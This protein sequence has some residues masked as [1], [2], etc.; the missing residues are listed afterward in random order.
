MSAGPSLPDAKGPGRDGGRRV[1]DRHLVGCETDDCTKSEEGALPSGFI[2]GGGSRT[3]DR[4]EKRCVEDILANTAIRRAGI[5]PSTRRAR[6]RGPSSCEPRQKGSWPAG[7]LTLTCYPE[8]QSCQRRTMIAAAAA[9]T[10]ARA[11]TCT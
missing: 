7:C 2:R 6:P 10:I 3:F 4:L 5:D 8:G 1:G 11:P 9:T